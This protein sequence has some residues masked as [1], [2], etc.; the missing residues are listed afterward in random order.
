MS[1][2]ANRSRVF[3]SLDAH[4]GDNASLSDSQS[5][6][7]LQSMPKKSPRANPCAAAAVLLCLLAGASSANPDLDAAFERDVLVV[8]AGR[9]ACHRLD[10]YLATND[11]QR[12]RGLMH[13]RELPPRTGMLFIYEEDA[14]L[15]MWMKNT[16][17]SLDMIF[18]RGDGTVASVVRNTE[19]LS[20]RSVAAT[21][22][23]RFVLELNAGIAA[24]LDIDENARLLVPHGDASDE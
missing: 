5:P 12:A 6:A 10:V 3:S 9:F 21:E 8:S 16:L 15:S 19:P 24:R 13:V 14:Y 20:L 18:A 23:V 1:G 17:I 7:V 22:P 2:Q 11:R 4:F